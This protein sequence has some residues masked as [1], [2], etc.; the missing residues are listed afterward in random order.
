VRFSAVLNEKFKTRIIVKNQFIQ[1]RVAAKR[2]LPEHQVK[3]HDLS[4]DKEFDSIVASSERI[5]VKKK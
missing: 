2:T 5:M 1:I 4:Q 3:L